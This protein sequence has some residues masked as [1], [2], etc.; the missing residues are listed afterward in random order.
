MLKGEKDKM[1]NI[2]KMKEKTRQKL[3]QQV[4]EEKMEYIEKQYS[5]RLRYV[6]L[7]FFGA[8]WL[9]HIRELA[10]YEKILIKRRGR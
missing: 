3:L 5:N 2:F 7:R 6:L 10:G 4:I 9:W 8:S 1:K